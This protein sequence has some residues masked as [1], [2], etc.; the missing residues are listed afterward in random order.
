MR[1]RK[2]KRT[3]IILLLLPYYYSLI[4]KLLQGKKYYTYISY[5]Y[6]IH[7]KARKNNSP[8]SGIALSI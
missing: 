7:L 2:I 6:I 5:V 4:L 3:K 1:V 8:P